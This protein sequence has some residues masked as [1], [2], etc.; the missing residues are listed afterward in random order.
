M[1]PAL[2]RSISNY[3]VLTTES[4]VISICSLIASIVTL[5]IICRNYNKYKKF[6]DEN[7]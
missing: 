4:L 5:I 7:K 6:Y 1:N 2:Y 3:G